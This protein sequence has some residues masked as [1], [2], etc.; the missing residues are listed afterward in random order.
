MSWHSQLI[1]WF[2]ILKQLSLSLSSFLKFSDL[3][4][5][6]SRSQAFYGD[7]IGSSPS[8]ADRHWAG[9]SNGGIDSSVEEE[10]TDFDEEE[11]IMTE[12][13]SFDEDDDDRNADLTA[14]PAGQMEWTD[15]QLPA[16]AYPRRLSSRGESS[17][18]LGKRERRIEGRSPRERQVLTDRRLSRLTVDQENEEER[19]RSRSRSPKRLNAIRPTSSLRPSY[20]SESSSMSQSNS[21]N[22]RARRATASQDEAYENTP[23]L[24]PSSMEARQPGKGLLRTPS[25][26]L[27]SGASAATAKFRVQGYGTSTFWQSW[28]NTVNALIG[29]GIL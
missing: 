25:W 16:N 3:V 2:G 4:W 22:Q 24:T 28:F 19:S 5:S 14:S 1:Q 10:D 8:F 29:V 18:T 15:E 9:P 7:N 17:G 23:L 27:S 12:D 20:G 13:A 11:E 6:Y 21:T 26:F